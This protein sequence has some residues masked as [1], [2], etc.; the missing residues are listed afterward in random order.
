MKFPFYT[1]RLIIRHANLADAHTLLALVNQP[2]F[3]KH[4]GDKKIYSLNSA[5][6][7]IKEA[8]I[9]AHE[10]QGFGPYIVTLQNNEV[11]GIVGFYQRSALQFPDLGFA[12]IAGFD[13]HGYIHEAALALLA[14]TEDF[15]ISTVCAITNPDNMASQNVLL[16]LGFKHRGSAYL[17]TNSTANNI[18]LKANSAF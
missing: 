4:I 7:Y 14:H 13:G 12:L 17:Y 18:F 3:I 2:N 8:F 1:Q 16:K 11:I 9:A 15:G 5:K 6:R 10:Q